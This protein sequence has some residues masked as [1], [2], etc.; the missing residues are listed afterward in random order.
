MLILAKKPPRIIAVVRHTALLRHKGAAQLAA[1]AGEARTMSRTRA[2]SFAEQRG[3][4]PE[5]GAK[6]H[7]QASNW[8][9]ASVHS[10]VHQLKKNSTKPSRTDLRCCRGAMHGT[11]HAPPLWRSQ[12][13][14]GLLVSGVSLASCASVP[15]ASLSSSLFAVIAMISGAV[16][17]SSYLSLPRSSLHY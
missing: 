8:L 16:H 14:I 3:H 9:A 5:V 11:S 7:Q 6:T 15:R 13:I 1:L 12:R 10:S 17:L 2:V 4:R